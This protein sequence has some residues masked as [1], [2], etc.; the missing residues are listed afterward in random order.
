VRRGLA[1]STDGIIPADKPEGLTSQA[2]VSLAS[3]AT[4]CGKAGHSGTLDK[5]ASGVLPVLAGRY[6]RLARFFMGSPKRYR[7]SISFG[8]GTD[9]LD[10]EGETIATGPLPGE[11]EIRA[12][13]PAF[14]G[15]VLQRPPEYSSVHVGGKRAYERALAGE[16]VDLAPRPVRIDDIR[17]LSYEDGVA[18]IEVDCG[19][20]TY[21]RAIARDI[22]A[23]CGTVAHVSRLR[24]TYAGGFDESEA[25]PADSL[26]PASLM[27]FTR[28]IAERIGLGTARLPASDAQAFLIGKTISASRYRDVAAP[29]LPR[30]AVFEEG[31]DRPLGVVRGVTAGPEY[32]L[33]LGSPE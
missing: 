4:G 9:T 12:A 24:R 29:D 14:L 26:S 22:A 3:R 2:L 31:T 17:L 28:A 33:V 21:I 27:P 1:N 32:E 11:A 16:T 6:T 23:S 13:I 7:A 5:F 20:G 15:E 18:V 10:P 30:H 19:P 8:T 25:V